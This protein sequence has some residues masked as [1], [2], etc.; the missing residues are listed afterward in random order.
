MQLTPFRTFLLAAAAE[1]VALP[2]GLALCLWRK[3]MAQFPAYATAITTVVG[4]VAARAYGEHREK[5]R[6]QLA[7]EPAK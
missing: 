5:A 2:G 3:D 7:Q 6:A 4:I 1:L